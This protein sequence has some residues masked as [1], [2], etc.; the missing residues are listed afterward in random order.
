L[1]AFAVMFLRYFS[2][3]YLFYI[4]PLYCILTAAGCLGAIQYAN[5]HTSKLLKAAGIVVAFAT[6]LI[7]WKP[8]NSFQEVLEPSVDKKS[9]SPINGVLHLDKYPVLNYIDSTYS[10]KEIKEL[11]L[12]TNFYEHIV[13]IERPDVLSIIKYNHAHPR[14]FNMLRSQIRRHDKGL[15]VIDQIRNT[16]GRKNFPAVLGEPFLIDKHVFK[17]TF[18]DDINHVYTWRKL[19]P[20]ELPPATFDY[21]KVVGKEKARKEKRQ[22]NMDKK[23]EERGWIGKYSNEYGF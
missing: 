14:R 17:M 20:E 19:E 13:G 7:L 2:A 4:L 3:K 15:L 10:E 9:W 1:L 6:V 21:E 12:I 23:K 18:K 11:V 8:Y 16:G 22:G 5:H